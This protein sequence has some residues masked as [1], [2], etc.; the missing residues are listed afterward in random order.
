MLQE[1]PAKTPQKIG[2]PQ[3]PAEESAF[4]MSK[5]AIEQIR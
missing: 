4:Q 2:I 3:A 1:I 5:S